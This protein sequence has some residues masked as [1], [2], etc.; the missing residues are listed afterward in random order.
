MLHDLHD[1]EDLVHVLPGRQQTLQQQNLV[2]HKHVPVRTAHYLQHNRHT[3]HCNTTDKTV[4][5]VGCVSRPVG[6]VGD[7][8][9][10]VVGVGDI[11]MSVGGVGGVGGVSMSVG[12]VG[13]VR[14]PVVGVGG[15]DSRL[16]IRR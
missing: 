16:R 15:G 4:G 3:T 2:V 11:S 1:V 13:G 12:G 7:I 5:G 14:V 9:V 6:G 10:P 8:S